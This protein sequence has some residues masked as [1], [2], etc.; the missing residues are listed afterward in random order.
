MSTNWNYVY[1]IV[2][3]TLQVGEF[4]IVKFAGP[5]GPQHPKHFSAPEKELAHPNRPRWEMSTNWNYVYYIVDCTLQVG[6]FDSWNSL[7]PLVPTTPTFLRHGKGFGPPQSPPIRENVKLKLRVLY[8]GLHLQVGGFDSWNLLA[9]LVPNTPN[10]SLHRKRI[11]ST[12]IA[13]D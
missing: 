3:C 5:T 12:P 6:A 2:D 4:D 11:W 8:C 13:P 1:Y 9:P 10:I 7:A